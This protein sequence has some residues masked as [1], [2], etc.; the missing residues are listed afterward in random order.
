MYPALMAKEHP[1]AKA[2][3]MAESGDSLT[4]GELDARS[5]Q[6][7]QLLRARGVRPG[8]TLVIVMENR[9]EWPVVV[10]AG[11][12]AGLYVTPVN[13]HLTST[14]LG[15]LL[16][17]ALAGEEPG[18][19]VTSAN[20][21]EA[22]AD[23]VR[24]L[25]AADRVTALNVDAVPGFASFHDELAAFPA[26][27]VD[28]ERLGA[29][30]LYSGGTTGRP[31]AFRQQ[32]LDIHPADAPARH[33]ALVTKLGIDA[34]TVFLSPAPNYH[35]A[36][37]TF[38]LIVLSLGGTVVCLE[39]F[40]AE[41]A[42][43]AIDRH[44]VTHSQ[45]VPTMLLRLLRLPDEVR[46]GYGL[47]SHRVAFTSGAPCSAELKD[48]VMRWWGPILHEY[49]GASEGYGHT[50]VSP[51][52][53]LTHP[54]TVGKPL[55]GRVHVTD[56]E[57]CVLP[58]GAVGKVWFEPE[59]STAYRNAGDQDGWRSVGDLGHLD[60]HGF[61]YLSG[62]ESHTIISGGVNIY[63]VEI[64]DVLLAHPR[65]LDAAVIPTPDPEF[66]EQ[67]TAV[68]EVS[69]EVSQEELIEHCRHRLARFKAPKTVLFVD[70][71]P[72]LPTGKLNKNSLREAVLTARAASTEGST[73]ERQGMTTAS[74]PRFLVLHALRVKGLASD[75]IV[76][77]IAGLAPDETAGYL[78]TLVE[79][80]LILRREGRMAGSMLTPAGKAAH[81]PLLEADVA[82]ADRQAA[83]A[84][85]YD[86]FLPINGDFKRVCTDWQLRADSGEP[87]DHTDRGYDEGVVAKLG[88]V[89]AHV[90]VV[91]KELSAAV[92]RFGAYA[93]R[94]DA[95][96]ERVKGGD[97]SAFARPMADSYHDIWME[98]HQDLL[99]SLRKERGAHDEG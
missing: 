99:L 97:V 36:P 3:V 11:M 10:A 89:H 88:E 32:L 72:R 73:D 62:R 98:L 77:A 80:G 87:N 24:N 66:G 93:T 83:L 5:N 90:A 31:K 23:A 53:A 16:A 39:R 28:D 18:A 25:D 41:A 69:D 38:Q 14:E 60:E 55:S 20:C 96:L 94:L 9:I 12:R 74:D 79:E 17:E 15:A 91:L 82:G 26:T 2:Y 61:L 30:V 67:V 54:G 1:D 71:L 44:R 4:Y 63:P 58:S 19:V 37:F 49:Y 85:A 7:A 40:D 95:A 6:L 75:E 81:P 8:G 52:D 78:A 46:A 57:G 35:A 50:Y 84:A 21:A 51:E 47:D 42:L 43:A 56:D 86:A 34:E 29:R 92:D 76:G 68:V 59:A 64:E 27:P 22:V 65:V 70:K 45:W 33:G 48:E 13:W